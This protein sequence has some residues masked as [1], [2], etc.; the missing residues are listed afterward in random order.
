MRTN[1]AD[2][3]PHLRTIPR[4]DRDK[5]GA[6]LAEHPFH[7]ERRVARHDDERRIGEEAAD[8]A[9]KRRLERA[10]R[11]EPKDD[12]IGRTS[13]DLLEKRLVRGAVDGDAAL[14]LEE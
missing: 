8:H 11:G 12:G 14:T 4:R 3:V 1:G 2:H 13:D 6:I 10:G 9:K 7:L 5:K